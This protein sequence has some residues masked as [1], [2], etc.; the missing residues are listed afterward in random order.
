[1]KITAKLFVFFLLGLTLI[2]G[3]LYFANHQKPHA[4]TDEAASRDGIL[5]DESIVVPDETP[6]PGTEAQITPAPEVSTDTSS[7]DLTAAVADSAEPSPATDEVPEI[8]AFLREAD[9]SDRYSGSVIFSYAGDGS[10]SHYGPADST[11][12]HIIS[13][14]GVNNLRDIGGWPTA[15]GGI[16]RYGMLFR[17]AEIPVDSGE[18]TIQPLVSLGIKTIVD[19]RRDDETDVNNALIPEASYY[20]ARI[21]RYYFKGVDLSDSEALSKTVSALRAIM[22]SAIAGQ[23]CLFHCH[24]GADRTETMTFLLN[25]LCGV[26]EADLDKD[27]ELTQFSFSDGSVRS[28]DDERYIKMKEYLSSFSEISLQDGIYNWFLAAGFDRD[29]LD[30]FIQNMIVIQ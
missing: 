22:D 18:N 12:I 5:S 27:Y 30:S 17:S 28:R 26:S 29:Y 6:A 4:L 21:K 15:D 7:I 2:I 20:K 25:G 9:Y 11:G 24:L 10:V 13:N 19:L 3:G 8:A 23:P 14:P 16:I 1:M